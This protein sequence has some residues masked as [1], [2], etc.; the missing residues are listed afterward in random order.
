[1]L[2]HRVLTAAVFAPALLAAIWYGGHALHGACLLLCMLMLW[3]FFRMTLG[4]QDKTLKAVGYLLALILCTT[5]LNVSVVPLSSDLSLLPIAILVL[6][7]AVLATPLP[8]DRAMIR[9]GFVAFGVLYAAGLLPFLARLRDSF[10]ET[11]L[12]LSLTALF[13]TWGADTG[14]YFAGRAFGRHKLHP[15]I[16]PGKT[17]EGG[18]GG[19]MSAVLIAFF[20]RWLLNVPLSPTHTVAIGLIAGVFGI[21]GD[22]CESLLKRSVGAKDSSRLIPGHGGVLDRFDGVIFVAPAIWIYGEMAL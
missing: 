11:G 3:E 15:T 20:I 16:S 6:F 1:M 2:I 5:I 22:L 19:L 4:P 9:I 7:V 18:I 13:C 8:I 10:A 14:A 12:G 21:L 17:I